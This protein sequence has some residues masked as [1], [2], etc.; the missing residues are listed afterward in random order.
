MK[1]SKVDEI[2]PGNEPFVGDMTKRI[3]ILKDIYVHVS[4]G[5]LEEYYKIFPD[6]IELPEPEFSAKYIGKQFRYYV[7]SNCGLETDGE[8]EFTMQDHLGRKHPFLHPF[9]MV[10]YG[11]KL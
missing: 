3:C 6:G 10:P 9:A 8:E 5:E 4:W 2:F 11:E 1:K 7:C